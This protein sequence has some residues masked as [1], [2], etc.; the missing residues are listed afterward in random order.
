MLD[1]IGCVLKQRQAVLE[2]LR[3][4]SD[5]QEYLA[6]ED[7]LYRL[8]HAQR[9]LS[10]RI[11][12]P[13]SLVAPR[14]AP[15]SKTAEV[16][17]HVAE[18]LRRAHRPMPIRT[19]LKELEGRGVKIG[20]KNPVTNLSAKLSA[21]AKFKNERRQGWRVDAPKKRIPFPGFLQK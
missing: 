12:A 17:D 7:K 9:P 14:P 15:K 2:R 10:V 19:I 18:I 20:G 4:N 5:F 11:P 16:K 3:D 1:E 21:D 6:L 8:T 13:A